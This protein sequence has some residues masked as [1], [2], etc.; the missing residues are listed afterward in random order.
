[1]E[2]FDSLDANVVGPP[3][4]TVRSRQVAGVGRR[5]VVALSH[6]QVTQLQKVTLQGLLFAMVGIVVGV[7][8]GLTVGHLL[9]RQFATTLGV[10][11]DATTPWGPILATAPAIVLTGAATAIGPAIAAGRSPNHRPES[12]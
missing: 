12:E 9:W 4:N 2:V 1:M 11:S 6:G 8:L 7:P 10:V 5:E 3:D